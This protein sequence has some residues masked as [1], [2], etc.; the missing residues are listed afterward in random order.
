MFRRTFLQICGIGTATAVT[1]KAGTAFQSRVGRKQVT[2]RGNAENVI[3][4]NL[5]GGASHID[6][7]DFKYGNWTPADFNPVSNGA[8]ELPAGLFPELSNRMNNFSLLRGL[9]HREVVHQR[10]GYLLETAHTFNPTFAKEQPHLG[11]LIAYELYG[12]RTESDIFP[13]FLA[14]N[15]AVQ[16]PGMLAGTY[17]PFSLEAGQGVPGLQHPQGEDMYRARYQSLLAV[18]AAA[19][20]GTAESGAVISDF[21]NYYKLG[22]DLAYEQDVVDAFSLAEE[23]QTRYGNSGVGAGCALAVQTLAKGRGTHVVQVNQGG[24]DQHYDIYNRNL[25]N[26]IYETANEL[27]KA[28]ATMLDD[29]A[30]LPGRRG[31]TLLDETLVLVCGEFGRTPGDISGNAGRD[32]YPYA[33]AALVAGGGIVPGQAFGATDS[34]GW[35][36][37]DRFWSQ[38]RDIHINDLIATI[39]SSLGIDWTKEIEDTPSGR[40]YEYTPKENGIAGYYT[41]IVEMFG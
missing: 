22:N 7:F 11:S 9:S 36:P 15:G 14:V 12:R 31:G 17:A 1:A 13:T 29:L 34:G 41:D 39:Y 28:V 27:D 23:T 30:A 21:H 19:R 26:N 25:G 33:Y 16:G 4:V 2:P 5:A 32:H 38:D 6:T 18:D 3:I 10:A 20:S 37:S 24:W 8:F 35:A 40:V